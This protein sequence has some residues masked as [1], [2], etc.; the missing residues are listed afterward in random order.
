MSNNHTILLKGISLHKKQ[1][2]G[3]KSAVKKGYLGAVISNAWIFLSVFAV[4]VQLSHPQRSTET[5]RVL[6]ALTL[7]E[8]GLTVLLLSRSLVMFE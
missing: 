8:T 5:T 3:R 6:Y 4:S 1:C 2:E 7:T